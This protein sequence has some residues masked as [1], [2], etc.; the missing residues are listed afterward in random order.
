[1]SIA[2]GS[3]VL[4]QPNTL[5]GLRPQRFANSGREIFVRMAALPLGVFDGATQGQPRRRRIGSCFALLDGTASDFL[6]DVCPSCRLLIA[7]IKSSAYLAWTVSS[8]ISTRAENLDSLYELLE[9]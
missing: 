4:I 9:R 3:P 6:R 2:R 1:M 7:R 8:G 5:L